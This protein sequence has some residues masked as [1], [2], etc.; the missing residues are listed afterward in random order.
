MNDLLSL[1]KNLNIPPEKVKELALTAQQ[2]PFAA[3]G[4]VQQLGVSPELLQQLM[5]AFMSNP[6]I[7]IDLAKQFGVDETTIASARQHLSSL[8]SESEA[9]QEK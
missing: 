8:G 4:M 3:M 2:N 6:A 5:A 7:L 1:V 9:P